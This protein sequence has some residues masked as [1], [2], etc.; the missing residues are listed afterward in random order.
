MWYIIDCAKEAKIICGMKDNV[1]QQDVAEIIESGRIKENLT[2]VPIKKG[3]AI[4]IPAGTIHAIL[5]DTLI[6][7]IQQNSNS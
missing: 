4:Y 7:E 6:C 2:Y 5:G 3:D 1:K